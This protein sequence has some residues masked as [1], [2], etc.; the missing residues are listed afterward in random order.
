MKHRIY[1]LILFIV[2]GG[3]IA[4]LT[5]ADTAAKEYRTP[6]TIKMAALLERL[7]QETD[8][9]QNNFLN[10]ERVQ[11]LEQA[12][13]TTTDP[14][15]LINLK[16]LY[17]IELL[18]LGNSE[19]ALK[20]FASFKEYA[21][22]NN[23]NMGAQNE[24]M[25]ENLVAVTQLRI[26]EQDNCISNHTALSC[27][28]PIAREGVH[29]YVRGSE[30]AIQTLTNTLRRFP[31]DQ[32]AKWLL[33]VAYMTLGKY[34]EQVPPQYLLDPRLFASDYDIKRFPEIAMDLGL[35]VDD[36][37]GGTI[38]EDFDG[39]GLLDILTSSWGMRAPMHFFKNMGNGS[40]EDRTE[41]AGLKGL[42]NG[43][44]MVQ[45][46]YNNDGRPDVLVMRG[47]WLGKSGH[48]PNSLLRNN[49]DGTF[50][51]VTEEAGLLD[52]HP[53]QA[54][55]WND[56]NNDGWLDL[57]IGNESQPGDSHPCKLYL[58]NRN[59]TFTE[60]AEAAGVANVGF[61]KGVTSGDYDN[62]GRVDLY[63]SRR[64]QPNILFH[65]DGKIDPET[66]KSGGWKFSNVTVKAGVGEPLQSFPTWF[67]D[68]D[69]DGWL[70]LFVT[71][72]L[73]REVGDI[74]S[75]YEGTPH[76]SERAR[77]FRNNRDGT[78]KDVSKEV[79]L[80]RLLFTMGSNFGD[81]DNDGWLDM[82]LGT[83]DPEYATLLPNR[84][85]RNNGGKNF[86]DVTTS[87]G[88][89]HL[90]KG[91]AVS[92]A[93]LDEDGDQDIYSSIGG[94]Y[95][96][97]HYRNVLF[98]N[99]GHG[100]NWVKLKLEGVQANRVAIG[101]RIKLT[102][103]EDGQERTIYKTVNTGGSFGASPLRQEIGVGKATVI[104]KVEILWPT[105]QKTQTFTNVAVN[106]FYSLK[107]G[108]AELQKVNFK[109]MPFAKKSGG[110]QHQHP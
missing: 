68:Y 107:E 37:A 76:K 1:W 12:L 43:L 30:A 42:I 91:H 94:A 101:A 20:E 79:G 83:G 93:D 62:D 98:E 41:Q 32:Q 34:P 73:L 4:P 17:A 10:A 6:G 96:G 11:M 105:T 61:V 81:F 22:A 27:L 54:V 108:D 33:N 24:N 47:A 82:Y 60:C 38:T 103:K 31:K 104:E 16:P 97:D 14:N 40:F 3:F 80:D 84:A 110:H 23:V 39:D 56:F 69:N 19:A 9:M 63:L 99:P 67:W 29:K 109:T 55:T 48:I 8:P 46:D 35:D 95:V 106:Q 72:Y 26:G 44:Y 85:F 2:S 65:N 13:K 57:F 58:N 78:F 88:M 90:Q 89:G 75:D 51:D 100:N 52:F 49:G 5:A 28:F 59:G 66:T 45:G 53:S 92:F 21:K 71:G 87:S 70:D 74:V 50:S 102:V 18:R 36:T 25:L 7:V 15:Q 77:L 86:Q 64:G